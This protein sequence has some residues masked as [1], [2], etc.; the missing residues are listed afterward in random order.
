MI[1][2]QTLKLPP[3]FAKWRMGQEECV[4]AVH[5]GLTEHH[6]FLLEAPTGVGKSVIALAAHS[7]FAT[8]DSVLER[9]D[10]GFTIRPHCVYVTRTKQ[11]QSQLLSEF[12]TA[13]TLFGRANYPCANFPDQFPEVTA[14]D[15]IRDSCL[16]KDECKYLSAKHTCLHAPI[17]VL[18]TSYF[19]AE[20][21]GPG[22]FSQAK[23]LILDEVDSLEGALMS[24]IQV[25]V[26]SR[27]L[28]RFKVTLPDQDDWLHWRIWA[29]HWFLQLS[30]RQHNAERQLPL[31]GQYSPT[32]LK[33]YKTSRELEKFCQ[34]L[35]RIATE[36]E[37]SRWV[38]SCRRDEEGNQTWTFQPI[39]VSDYS[40]LITD[41]GERILGMSGTGPMNLVAT[42]LGL[43]DYGTLQIPSPFPVEGRPIYY[44]PV[45]NLVHKHMDLELPKLLE[46]VANI[47]TRHP[48]E[49]ILVH[50]TSY[51]IRDYLLSRLTSPRV[52]THESNDRDVKLQEY[53]DTIE[54]RVML[55]PSF[56]RGVDLPY[57]QCR[58]VVI[59]KVPYLSLADAQVKARLD[60]PGGNTWYQMRAVQTILQMSGRGIRAPDDYCA[61]YI[62]DEQFGKLFK[63]AR[64][65]FPA[66]WIAGFQSSVPAP[67]STMAN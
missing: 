28:A 22:Q 8:E 55:S 13:K 51:G 20:A 41:H 38:Y 19:L 44:A 59:A 23:T 16:K 27:Q 7:M 18:N 12:P 3:R 32:D 66:W 10:S 57:D 52:M 65:L 30:E 45:A 58:I 33:N 5:A 42:N 49:K 56:D 54:P 14:D 25:V 40:D 31:D 53:K 1:D 2:I 11:L 48:Q 21:N 17:S 39:F 35:K 50:T 47:M 62:L 63:R 26:S 4:E 64:D 15:C 24:H 67:A 34:K 61:T 43:S 46:A 37:Q 29:N 60:A 6:V 36:I 9:L